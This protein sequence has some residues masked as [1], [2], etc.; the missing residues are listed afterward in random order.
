MK[1]I[2]KRE[3]IEEYF[4]S[5]R[6]NQST[7]KD[8]I[9]GLQP[10]LDKR[11]KRENQ[12][13]T[14]P[15]F[16]FGQAVETLLEEG[17]EAFKAN[18]YV[19]ELSGLPSDT[20]IEITEKVHERAKELSL[21]NEAPV[22]VEFL[23]Y[24]DYI[25][26]EIK[27]KSY[28]S[29]RKMETNINNIV[30]K[31]STYFKE[32]VLSEGKNI[33][34][35]EEKSK[36]DEVVKS[37]RD[38][39]NTSKYFSDIYKEDKRIHIYYQLPLYF[40][41]E[42]VECKALL[43]MAIVITDEDNNALIIKPIDLKTM[44]GFTLDFPAAARKYRYDIQAAFYTL[45]FYQEDLVVPE[46]FPKITEETVIDP[47]EFVVES[48]SNPGS[49]LV[50]VTDESFISSGINGERSDTGK[51][52]RYGINYLIKYYKYLSENNWEKERVVEE[53]NGILTLTSEGIL[54]MKN[55]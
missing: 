54:E 38:S 28:Y 21:L 18:F 20:E 48:S 1:I 45:A 43:D 30:N 47:F 42:G 14:P 5:E 34:S 49:P 53:N 51:W 37:L 16:I 41:Y 46:G 23:H 4:N 6:V 26:K 29:N 27:E 3:D 35:S 17:E 52:H 15:Y 25:E 22:S 33:I 19:S 13:V 8:L 32:L 31:C 7:L 9:E 11:T 40:T 24:K 50:Y 2:T 44:S 39:S 36:I 10:F 55:D 12:V